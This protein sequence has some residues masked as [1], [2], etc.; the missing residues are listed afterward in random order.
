MRT[1]LAFDSARWPIYLS[2]TWGGLKAVLAEE[3]RL[4]RAENGSQAKR[5]ART[6]P[7]AAIVRKLR[8]L[9]SR[10]LDEVAAE[11]SEF[12]LLVAKR[13]PD[14]EIVLLGEVSHDIALIERA[15]KHLL[16]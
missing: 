3:R 16:A 12:T 9:E 11:G 14:G 6:A 8:K 4:R 2:G 10:P 1:A 5:P 15:A 7:S 13:A